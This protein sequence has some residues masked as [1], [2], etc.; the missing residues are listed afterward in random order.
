MIG[1]EDLLHLHLVS[2]ILWYCRRGTRQGHSSVALRVDDLPHQSHQ[3]GDLA[4]DEK[5]GSEAD[6]QGAVGD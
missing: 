4:I 6:D 3:T 5:V 1:P 2:F